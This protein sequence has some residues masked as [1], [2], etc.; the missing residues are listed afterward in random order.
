MGLPIARCLFWSS[1]SRHRMSVSAAASGRVGADGR[2]PHRPPDTANPKPPDVGRLK[3]PPDRTPRK[4]QKTVI[5]LGRKTCDPGRFFHAEETFIF[6]RRW[7]PPRAIWP[8][9]ALPCLPRSALLE[10]F[11]QG[12]G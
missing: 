4:H 2:W 3:E 8:L 1:V 11:A 5:F 7:P 10:R 6:L 12:D 9:P